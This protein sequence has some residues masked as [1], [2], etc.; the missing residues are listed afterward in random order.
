VCARMDGAGSSSARLAQLTKNARML[1][2]CL[3]A[4]WAMVISRSAK[5]LPRSLCVPNERRRHRTNSRSS[6]SA[7]LCRVPDYAASAQTR[8]RSDD[9][10]A[11]TA[12]R[13]C[14]PTRHSPVGSLDWR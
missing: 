13:R 6:R 7:W 4:V 8:L 9:G 5:R 14:L 10:R 2:P 1:R 3:R 11:R 12:Q